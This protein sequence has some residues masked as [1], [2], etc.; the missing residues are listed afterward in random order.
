[1]VL[2]GFIEHH[3]D[4]NVATDIWMETL[5]EYSKRAHVFVPYVTLGPG[6]NLLRHAPER[7]APWLWADRFA[8]VNAFEQVQAR[9][10]T[11]GRRAT[12]REVTER[13]FS[14][15]DELCRARHTRLIVTLL[16]LTDG[17][18]RDYLDYCRNR[19]IECIDCSH[20]LTPEMLV[21][22]DNHPNPKMHEIWAECI[23]RAVGGSQR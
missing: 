13:L 16:A 6:A 1:M 8:L 22:G 12:K 18:K 19:N 9:L 23:A 5:A 11:R 21:P 7:Y 17:A 2:Y 3:E 15:M 4:R 14:S 10:M 20:P